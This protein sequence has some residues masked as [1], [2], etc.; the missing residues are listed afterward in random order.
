M[1]YKLNPIAEGKAII[2][3]INNEKESLL[4]IV[5]ISF[6]AKAD[7]IVG[8]KAVAKAILKES[9]ITVNISILELN[10][11]Y[12]SLATFSP[13]IGVNILTTVIESIFLLSVPKTAE[14]VIG[15]DTANILFNISIL[16][17]LEAFENLIFSII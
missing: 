10:I 7:E 16:F 5:L 6:L 15:I 13:K 17:S 11:P 4:F 2:H 14:I 1:E 9:G 8:T 12:L 3:D